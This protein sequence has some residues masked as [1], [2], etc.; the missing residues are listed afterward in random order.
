VRNARYQLHFAGV[1]TSE[2]VAFSHLFATSALARMIWRTVRV[3]PTCPRRRCRA[4]NVFSTFDRENAMNATLG[5]LFRVSV[6]AAF[7]LALSAPFA[8]AQNPYRTAG[9]K[10]SG[11]AYWPGRAT[12]Q[13]L[14]SAQNYA[15]EFQS[16]VATTPKPEPAVVAEVHKTLTNYLDE[17]NK[18]LGSMK[19]DFA[20]DKETLAAID[21]MEKGLAT[22]VSHHKA[23]IESLKN[24]DVNKVMAMSSAADLSKELGKVHADHIALMKKLSEKHAK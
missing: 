6:F 1:I 19:K 14:Q 23:M 15:Q 20:G 24:E 13:Y 22:A 17:S 10:I 3:W 7:A 11:N 8:V 2:K 4:S 16:Y 12:T 9:E 5:N 18:H 21:K